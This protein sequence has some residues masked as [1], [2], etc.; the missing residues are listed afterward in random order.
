V[1]LVPATAT[2]APAVTKQFQAYG[3]TTVGD[4]ISVKVDFVAKGG[5][6]TSGGLYTA[7]PTAGTFN[8]I[9]TSG[10]LADT[11]V[12]TVNVPLGS[13][14]PVGIPFGPFKL[15]TGPISTATVGVAPFSVSMDYTDA[16][17]IV[18]RIN[19]ARTKKLKL[20]LAM[21]DNGHAA[22]I[23]NGVF[24]MVKWKAA[25]D[26]YNTPEIKAAVA[27][28]VADGTII[29]NSVMDEP[30]HKSWGGVVNKATVDQM[31]TYVKTAFPTL[32]VG[33]GVVHWWKP[34][35]RYQVCDF[36]IDQYDWWQSPNGPGTQPGTVTSWRDAATAMAAANGISI[37]FSLNILDGGTE[38]TGCPEP[39]TGGPGTYVI[40]GRTDAPCRMTATQVRDWGKT[41]GVAG[42]ALLMWRYDTT[43]MSRPD[44][45]QAL[46]D[47]ASLLVTRARKPCTRP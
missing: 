17:L 23:T 9:A 37:V 11:S 24:D 27:D 19:V 22:Y 5:T 41:L 26:T 30:N 6:V 38:V 47:V 31:C 42:C 1:I 15:W 25:M 29:G 40:P 2:L 36:I 33:V 14:S 3:R 10:T 21:T 39:Q 13:G 43:F 7:G 16:G 8:V 32:P 34:T 4:S 44:N 35:E 28:G 20:M 45:L 46:Q 18:Q 12:V